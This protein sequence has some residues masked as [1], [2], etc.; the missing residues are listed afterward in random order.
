MTAEL[1]IQ[2]T[3]IRTN[4]RK[5][6]IVISFALMTAFAIALS[7][8]KISTVTTTTTASSAVE[9]WSKDTLSW[10]QNW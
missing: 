6:A 10:K 1:S 9:L 2:H 5:I 7:T 4:V 3:N 8:T